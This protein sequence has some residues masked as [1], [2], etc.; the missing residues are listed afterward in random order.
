MRLGK[1]PVN[2]VGEQGCCAHDAADC[3]QQ[4]RDQRPAMTVVCHGWSLRGFPL[5]TPN[6]FVARAQQN[7]GGL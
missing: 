3:S 5:S 7:P 2:E 1:H 6:L 4:E